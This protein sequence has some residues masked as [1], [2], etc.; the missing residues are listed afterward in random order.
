MKKKHGIR[1]KLSVGGGPAPTLCCKKTS[2]AKSPPTEKREKK[3]ALSPKKICSLPEVLLRG[4]FRVDPTKRCLANKGKLGNR[5]PAARPSSPGGN[6]PRRPQGEVKRKKGGVTPVPQKSSALGLLW[7]VSKWGKKG[8]RETSTS[9]EG[10]H[11]SLLEVTKKQ[12]C[13][14]EDLRAAKWDKEGLP[15]VQE[16][17]PD[18]HRGTSSSRKREVV[19][20]GGVAVRSRGVKTTEEG[21]RSRALERFR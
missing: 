10:R 7:G 18:P 3:E 5:G 19:G 4:I 20:G 14:E 15:S 13:P 1:P 21:R 11:Y 12:R 8:N 16:P 17:S 2:R 6:G 9:K